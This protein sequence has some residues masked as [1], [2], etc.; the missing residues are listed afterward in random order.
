MLRSIHYDSVFYQN[1]PDYFE[2]TGIWIFCG[3]QGSGKTLSAVRTLKKM[4]AAWPKAIVCS[5]I[6]L[7]GIDREIIPFTDYDQL[8][9]LSNGING[10]IFLIDEIHVLWNSLE[11]KNIPISEMAVFCQMRKERRVIIRSEERRVG[12]EC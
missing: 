8:L 1:N 6:P 3:A 11:S 5:N 4:L 10:I 12:K 9:K 7:S 2:P